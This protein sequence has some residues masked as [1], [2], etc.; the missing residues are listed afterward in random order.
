MPRENIMLRKKLV[1]SINYPLYSFLGI[2]YFATD[3]DANYKIKK[4]ATLL[5]LLW[6]FI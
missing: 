5:T 6:D 1:F 4:E 3:C 2:I